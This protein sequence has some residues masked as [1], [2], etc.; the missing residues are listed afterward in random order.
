MGNE[1]SS[2]AEQNDWGM[3]NNAT[4]RLT[5]RIPCSPRARQF[6]RRQRRH[7]ALVRLHLRHQQHQNRIPRPTSPLCLLSQDHTN[8][9]IL[10]DTVQSAAQQKLPVT[11]TVFSAKGQTLRGLLTLNGVDARRVPG[12][13]GGDRRWRVTSMVS[14]FL[15]IKCI[16]CSRRLSIIASRNSRLH[17]LQRLHY[18]FP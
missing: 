4:T 12:A 6:P 13:N 10:P 14:S 1:Q 7:R 11:F 9:N 3:N 8:A 2:A 15:R 18:R 5:D 17:P 16:P